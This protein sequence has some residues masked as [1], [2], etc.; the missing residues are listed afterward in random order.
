M[1][2]TQRLKGEDIRGGE[3]PSPDAMDGHLS[4][5]ACCGPCRFE[6]RGLD[7]LTDPDLGK[8]YQL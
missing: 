2:V 7:D 1:A 8:R 5:V 4:Y 6:A 3:L